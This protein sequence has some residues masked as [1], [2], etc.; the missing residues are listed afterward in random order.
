MAMIFSDTGHHSKIEPTPEEMLTISREISLKFTPNAVSITDTDSYLANVYTDYNVPQIYADNANTQ[1]N[2]IY[3]GFSL[4]ELQEISEEISCRFAPQ[5]SAVIP[6]LFLLP[7]D[8]HHLYAYWDTG[9]RDELNQLT[10]RIYWRPDVNPETT[11]SNVWFD[12]VA[13]NPESR[14]KIRL[15]IDDTAYSAVLGKLKPDNSLDVL[16]CSNIVQVPPAP[17]RMRIAPSRNNQGQMQLEQG[18]QTA[19]NQ[20][21]T[22]DA[23][24]AFFEDAIFAPEL[25]GIHYDEPKV[26]AHFPEP[27]WFVKLHFGYQENHCGDASN[28]DSELMDIFKSKGIFVELIPESGFV[29]SSPVP[30]K[31]PSGQGM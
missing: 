8:P 27:G 28:I 18:T 15:P 13:D 30:V 7:V 26:G 4:K 11:S 16:A 17:G 22:I 9:D 1:S 25:Q 2:S 21:Q 19:P 10:L 29:E 3:S 31:N 23:G 12:V 6:E 20:Q 24:R 14:Q 5:P